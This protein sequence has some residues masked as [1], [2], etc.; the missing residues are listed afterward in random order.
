VLSNRP[1]PSRSM[2]KWLIWVLVPYCSVYVIACDSSPFQTDRIEPAFLFL[3][4]LAAVLAMVLYTLETRLGLLLLSTL[5][6]VTALL[7]LLMCRILAQPIIL[8]FIGACLALDAPRYLH[9]ARLS[10]AARSLRKQACGAA[11]LARFSGA[12]GVDPGHLRLAIEDVGGGAVI[13]SILAT[14]AGLV[15]LNYVNLPPSKQTCLMMAMT[16]I[17]ASALGSAAATF[18]RPKS[19]VQNARDHVA[20]KLGRATLISASDLQLRYAIYLRPFA[21]TGRLLDK[22][23]GRRWYDLPVFPQYYA[24]RVV[25]LESPLGDATWSLGL[26]FLGLGR[27]GEAFGA[28]RLSSTEATWKQNI[29]ALL[30]GAKM[31]FMIPSDHPGTLWEIGHI[32]EHR[33]GERCVFV[34]PWVVKDRYS[35]EQWQSTR[36]ACSQIGLELPEHVSGGALLRQDGA[37]G[38]MVQPRLKRLVRKKRWLGLAVLDLLGDALQSESGDPR[39]AATESGSVTVLA[40]GNPVLITAAKTLLDEAGIPYFLQNEGTRDSSGDGY[41]LGFSPAVEPVEICVDSRWRQAAEDLLAELQS[42]TVD[43][44]PV[45]AEDFEQGSSSTSLPEDQQPLRGR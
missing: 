4:A 19:S 17:I 27:P 28:G 25:E 3:M 34:M 41:L 39:F 35:A 33:A 18:F 10:H 38:W 32:M 23:A 44:L 37:G 2:I 5:I 20:E 7:G 12:I 24:R 40:T 31:I 15:I 13:G 22:K 42:A 29:A 1:N 14:L 8:F 45:E 21:V 9:F 16:A 36:A 30:A 6:V 26:P 43:P 11:A